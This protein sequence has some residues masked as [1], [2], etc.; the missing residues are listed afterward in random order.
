MYVNIPLN[1]LPL[2][3]CD[4]LIAH[5]PGWN[6]WGDNIRLSTFQKDLI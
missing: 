6:Y 3:I 1:E 4:I 2:E 5:E